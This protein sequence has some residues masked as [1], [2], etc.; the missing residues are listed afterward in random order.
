MD[1]VFYVTTPIY[2]VN[3]VPHIGHAYTTVIGD[4]LARFHRL[5]GYD[6]HLLTGTDEH[7]EKV[8]QAAAVAGEETQTFVDQISRRFRAA[9]E[10]LDIGYDDFLRTTEERHKKVVL[11]VL[12]RLHANGDIYHDEYEGIYCVGCERFL[13]DKELVEGKCPDHQLEPERRKEGNYFFRMEKYRSWLRDYILAHPGFIFP[14]GYRN[15]VL[16]LLGETIGDLSISRPKGRVPWGIELPWDSD[17]VAYV[18]IDA[19][20]NYISA[21][22]FGSGEK[23]GRYWSVAQHLIGKDILKPHAVFWPTMLKAAGI[24]LYRRLNVGGFLVGADGRKMSKSLG[25]VVDPFELARKYGADAV[26]Y[27]L[28]KDTVYGQDG[29]VGEASL[30]ERYNADLAN[31][32]GNLLARVRALLIRHLGGVLSTPRILGGDQEIVDAGTALARTARALVQD[33][34]IYASL[35]EVMQFV[36]LLNRYFSDEEPWSLARDPRQKER[37][38]TV[39]YNVVEGLRIVSVLL[40]PAMPRKAAEIRSSLGLEDYTME[41]SGRWG[42][43][44][45]GTRIPQEAPLLFPKIDLNGGTGAGDAPVET[46]DQEPKEPE[47][48]SQQISLEEFS[49]TELRIAE[50]MEAEKVT[51][52]DKLLKLTLSLGQE[53]RTVV[54]GIAQ[55]YEPGELVGRKVVLVA[56]LKPAKL[57]GI[58]SEG[59]VLAALGDGDQL[60][61]VGPDQD[62]QAGAVVR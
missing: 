14:S 58:V 46:E 55:S 35:E 15:E 39:L 3:D 44:P 33:M 1:K 25:N 29:A 45:P 19:L 48:M 51:G 16:S 57:R 4:F 60:A 59:M 62:I 11:E 37:L 21:I 28:L 49:R 53:R 56:N 20:L 10:V 6:T 12:R 2:Y 42:L 5:D 31:D 41:E 36:R 52:T 9:W 40:E 23:Y 54:S 18:W 7:G 38:G 13:T 26:R 24:P 27:Y 8:W 61:L 34:K 22:E 47:E 17:H 30:V 43:S 50:V 32:L